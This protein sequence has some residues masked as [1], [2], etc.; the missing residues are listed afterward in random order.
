MDDA[1]G[2][3]DSAIS[4]LSES[5]GIAGRRGRMLLLSRRSVRGNI[6]SQIVLF[7]TVWPFILRMKNRM[8]T[9][10]WKEY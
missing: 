2:V 4:G 8:A 9:V 6:L 10:I 1:R 3:L 7:L 5:L